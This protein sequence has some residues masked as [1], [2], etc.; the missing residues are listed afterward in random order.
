MGQRC[1][2][3]VAYRVVCTVYVQEPALSPAATRVAVALPCVQVTDL[4]EG[5]IAT[6]TREVPRF[7][8]GS[9]SSTSGGRPD[10]AARLA[11]RQRLATKYSRF[12]A[13]VSIMECAWSTCMGWGLAHSAPG[14]RD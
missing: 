10:A 5:E 14:K 9:K 4:V 3:H 6:A 7:A 12:E 11:S 13:E 1:L 2:L 8:A